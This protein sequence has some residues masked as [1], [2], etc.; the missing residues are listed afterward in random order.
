MSNRIIVKQVSRKDSELHL[1]SYMLRNIG[2]LSQQLLCI[3]SNVLSS[4]F[5]FYV[6]EKSHIRYE[7]QNPMKG[8]CRT[9]SQADL[10]PH[11]QTK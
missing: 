3:Q 6:E 2:H 10:H 1:I 11:M 9:S 4:V 5:E 7:W 8:S